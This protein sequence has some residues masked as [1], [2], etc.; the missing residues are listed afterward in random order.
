M[1][2]LFCHMI[3]L[4]CHMIGLFCRMM[5]KQ[6]TTP[7]N[8]CM[9]TIPVV[10]PVF[11]EYMPSP[12]P[13]ISKRSTKISSSCFHRSSLPGPARSGPSVRAHAAP[14]RVFVPC[15]CAAASGRVS[16]P[17][18]PGQSPRRDSSGGIRQSPSLDA[19]SAALAHSS[20]R[21]APPTYP[22]GGHLCAHTLGRTQLP[23]RTRAPAAQKPAAGTTSEPAKAHSATRR[24]VCHDAAAMR[25]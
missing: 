14:P 23:P 2:G 18:A 20:G 10:S 9:S 17:H 11:S 13:S 21:E 3:G 16:V 4:F 19:R 1:I 25:N 12:P 6:A 15:A 24:S 5:G 7:R 22:S 8:K